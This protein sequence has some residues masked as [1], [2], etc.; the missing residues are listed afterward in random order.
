MSTDRED[1]WREASIQRQLAGQ[2][3]P[4]RPWLLIAA[5]LLLAVLSVVLWAKWADSRDRADRL[6][7]EL[8]QVYA[9]AEAIRLQATRAQQRIGQLEREIQSLTA[10]RAAP[11]SKEP[12]RRPRP[13]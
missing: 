12:A 5:S 7:A 6:Q 4:R 11:S 3:Y 9:E 2:P 8:K 13:R 10:E 1:S